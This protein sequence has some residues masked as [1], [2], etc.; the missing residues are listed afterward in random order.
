MIMKLALLLIAFC[1]ASPIAVA[2]QSVDNN[3]AVRAIKPFDLSWLD[4]EERG[5]FAIR[6]NII[7]NE[8]PKQSK[9]IRELFERGLSSM[10]A[11]FKIDGKFEHLPEFSEIEQL[12]SPLNYKLHFAASEE[13]NGQSRGEFF[14]EF[15]IQCSKKQDWES[16]V[17][18]IFPTAEKAEHDGKQ[19]WRIKLEA[20]DIVSFACFYQIN[21]YTLLFCY[22][23]EK[24]KKV[25]KLEAGQKR[26]PPECWKKVETHHLAFMQAIPSEKWIIGA[27]TVARNHDKLILQAF[28]NFESIACGLIIGKKSDFLMVGMLH[29]SSQ[30]DSVLKANKAL[31][32]FW[33]TGDLEDAEDAEDEDAESKPTIWQKLCDIVTIEV[34]KRQLIIRGSIEGNFLLEMLESPEQS[35]LSKN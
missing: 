26:S 12:T 5:V 24:F 32:R 34:E 16:I 23:E 7:A 21:D 18:K 1:L 28:E 20:F 10:L 27:K 33:A 14:Q 3:R 11:F 17:K 13:E 2:Q 22:N 9:F 31:F 4:Y 30:S 29:Q 8:M 15:K 35:Q 6:P 25:C 19:Y